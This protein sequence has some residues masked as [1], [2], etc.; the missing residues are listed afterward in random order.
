M[1]ISQTQVYAVSV[2]VDKTVAD[3]LTVKANCEYAAS[4]AQV[5]VTITKNSGNIT[6]ARTISAYESDGK[7]TIGSDVSVAAPSPAA[8]S[9][10]GTYT[11]TAQDTILVVK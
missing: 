1:I 8:D 10:I 2:K 9:V 11:M 6:S 3:K 7:T 5:Q 4:G